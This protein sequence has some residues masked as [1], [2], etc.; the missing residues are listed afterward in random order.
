LLTSALGFSVAY[1]FDPDHGQARRKQAWTYVDRARRVR[2]HHRGG[3]NE[4]AAVAPLTSR[5]P[6][7]R[8]DNGVSATP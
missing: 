8:V 2:S 3:D 7:Q 4:S 6:F 1:F 5:A